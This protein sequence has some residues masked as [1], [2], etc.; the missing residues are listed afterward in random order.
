MAQQLHTRKT[1]I[2]IHGFYRIHFLLLVVRAV[3]VAKYGPR[4]G[5][6]W[7]TTKTSKLAHHWSH[8]NWHSIPASRMSSSYRK[9]LITFVW[10][11]RPLLWY[12]PSISSM[13]LW[14]LALIKGLENS[15]EIK[16]RIIGKQGVAIDT[17]QCD[18]ERFC[19][20]SCH[21][22]VATQRSDLHTG[23][24]EIFHRIHSPH[25]EEI[26]PKSSLSTTIMKLMRGESKPWSETSV[27]LRQTF[28][29]NAR[30]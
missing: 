15:M 3:I 13:V 23:S 5:T 21:I 4:H 16:M 6:N 12:P 2:A 14:K 30:I 20:T 28:F 18:N 8:L 29:N 22:L 17:R 11:L 25:K 19:S 9:L 10:A 27:Q 1:R 24:I 26:S 7:A